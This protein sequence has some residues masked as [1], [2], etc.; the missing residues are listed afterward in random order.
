MK[1]TFPSADRSTSLVVTI[2]SFVLTT[3]IALF[4][5]ARPPQVSLFVIY[6]IPL[7]LAVT[8]AGLWAG[9]ILSVLSVVPGF[10]ADVTWASGFM[11]PLVAGWNGLVRLCFLLVVTYLYTS[12]RSV[13][14]R[15]A[16]RDWA[17]PVT[18]VGSH[19]FFYQIAGAE[20]AR[21][22]RYRR[23]FSLAYV[24][25][26]GLKN[27]NEHL[28]YNA[29][30]TL[31]ALV[32]RTLDRES[33]KADVVARLGG[34]ELVLL[35]PETD[36]NG[37]KAVFR[38]IFATLSEIFQEDGWPATLSIGVVT[39]TEAPSTVDEAIQCAEECMYAAKKAGKNRVEF[40]EWAKPLAIAEGEGPK[41]PSGTG[42]AGSHS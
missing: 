38:R 23:P 19:S 28:G 36:S 8:Y 7:F 5:Y 20:L 14:Q 32:A 10:I 6:L 34:D 35:M 13:Q 4:D 21:M 3:L 30:D 27:V 11:N 33:R 29:G 16:A 26:D 15:E 40:A 37:A 25:I 24:D 9:I 2:L 31:L 1:N 41:P 42:G 22:R 39:F 17:D 18:G 12:L